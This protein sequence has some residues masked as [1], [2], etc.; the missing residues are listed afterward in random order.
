MLD[1]EEEGLMQKYK[2][3]EEFIHQGRMSG[4]VLVHWYASIL[5]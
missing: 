2:Q 1:N 4:K 3:C 5:K